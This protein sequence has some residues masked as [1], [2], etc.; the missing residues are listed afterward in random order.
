[1]LNFL[2]I[3]MLSAIF[4]VLF[5]WGF[6]TLQK[7]R[8]QILGAVPTS[9]KDDTSW[10]GVNLT[11]YG[12]FNAWAL[13]LSVVTLLMLMGAASV[14]VPGILC[15]TIPILALCIPASRKI[16]AW[17]EKKPATFSIAGAFFS[18]IV[19]AP[20]VIHLL[21]AMPIVS[22]VCRFEPM[23]GL[24]ALVAAYAIGEGIGRLACI[25]YGCCYGKPINH[26]PPLIQNVFR[27]RNFTF[28]GKTKK[29]AYAH[30]WDGEKVFPV[31]AVTA[32]FN[33]VTGLLGI[34][35]FLNG[36][37]T[38]SFLLTLLFTQLWRFISEFLRADHRGGGRISAYQIMSL[39]AMPYA[40][41]VAWLFPVAGS[42]VPDMTNGFRM[43]WHP[44]ILIFVELLWIAYFLYTGRS[45][46]TEAVISFQVRPDRI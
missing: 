4:L 38:A 46:V 37:F 27:N 13:A 12:F 26:L 21:K 43:M 24:S 10:H 9:K 11:F 1:M 17:V 41:V 8:W 32:V 33:G 20:L 18:G 36:K 42:T 30:G 25:S 14:P 6:R 2:F 15:M 3:F 31:Q 19:T 34:V 29:I 23:V 45:R 7:E 28:T 16:A 5:T 44:G 39:A 40:V 22:D 35:L